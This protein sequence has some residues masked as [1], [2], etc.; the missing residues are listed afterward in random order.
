MLFW[1]GILNVFF[2][3]R[4][5]PR[6]AWWANLP[7]TSTPLTAPVWQHTLRYASWRWAIGLLGLL[8]GIIRLPVHSA[9]LIT[10]HV[11]FLFY[12]ALIRRQTAQHLARLQALA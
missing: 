2:A 8:L 3:H 11:A 4:P 12:V 6:L 10:C 7:L 5:H 1:L 9:A